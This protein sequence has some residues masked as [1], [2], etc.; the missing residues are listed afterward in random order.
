MPSLSPFSLPGRFW[1]GNLHTHSTL[2]DGALEPP[3]VIEAYKN[4]GTS[5][6]LAKPINIREV[7]MAVAAAA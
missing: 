7:L 5:G 6:V 1:R 4:A 2:S 3:Q